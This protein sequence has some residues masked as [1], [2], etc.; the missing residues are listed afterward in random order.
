MAGRRALLLVSFAVFGLCS[1][2][3]S[4]IG[5]RPVL[6]RGPSTLQEADT[7]IVA[8]RGVPLAECEEPLPDVARVRI[9]STRYR[10]PTS[11]REMTSL[12]AR[13]YLV[14]IADG[15]I[16]L[17]HYGTGRRTMVRR[18]GSRSIVFWGNELR[19]A[20]SVSPDGR[21]LVTRDTGRGEDQDSVIRIW[22]LPPDQ[23]RTIVMRAMLP[24]ELGAWLYSAAF[25]FT[26]DGRELMVAETNELA[27]FDP[28]TGRLLR[29]FK[30]GTAILD[31][32]PAAGRFLTSSERDP[33]E[34]ALDFGGIFLH[35]IPTYRFRPPADG[36]KDGDE[37]DSAQ[38]P[39]GRQ[40][41]TTA[42]GQ[43]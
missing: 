7:P 42:P 20:F 38:F 13:E 27:V 43:P 3:G 10:Y 30:S 1:W 11:L 15:Q 8:M 26:P 41:G 17:T 29:S 5:T 14:T 6:G 12:A 33:T 32:A 2:L 19:T 28:S 23:D 21:R 35:R 4:S 34:L 24:F 31:V 39:D 37:P 9:G 16:R 36:V 25:H 18:T 40:L 22:D